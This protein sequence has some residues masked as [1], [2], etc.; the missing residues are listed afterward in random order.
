[1]LQQTMR[2]AGE[3]LDFQE[4]N[5]AVDLLTSL[6]MFELGDEITMAEMELEKEEIVEQVSASIESTVEEASNLL[7]ASVE[8]EGKGMCSAAV[9]DILNTVQAT[10]KLLGVELEMPAGE[11]FDEDTALNTRLAGE[12]LKD[13][14]M[15]LAKGAGDFIKRIIKATKDFFK[16]HL[17][18]AGMLKKAIDKLEEAMKG[19][20]GAPKEAELK[21]KLKALHG[22][23]PNNL[24]AD[25][26]ANSLVIKTALEDVIAGTI[27]MADGKPLN[28]KF[29]VDD[30]ATE[31][32]RK[33]LRVTKY[34]KVVSHKLLGKDEIVLALGDIFTPTL[35]G[36][37][38]GKVKKPEEQKIT[39]SLASAETLLS[40]AAGVLATLE[41]IEKTNEK[42]SADLESGIKALKDADRERTASEIRNYKTTC[43][44]L[45]FVNVQLAKHQTQVANELYRL[46]FKM[47]KQFASE[48]K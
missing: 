23:T 13:T 4:S 15:K 40:A 2:M 19:K 42:I 33:A 46:A 48:E 34:E 16:K 43:R 21:I 20:T 35:Y 18:R 41:S 31:E 14:V 3:S 22:S 26:G 45:L 47:A 6:T 30:P 29:R 25:A 10:A 27:D 28:L 37:Y 44:V 24:A 36:Y 8:G 38:N 39:V 11:S 1:M 17:S 12:G 32:A 9:T 7:L 5:P